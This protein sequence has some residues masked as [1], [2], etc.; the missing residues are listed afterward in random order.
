MAHGKKKE[1]SWNW[2]EKGQR[3]KCIMVEPNITFNELL[4]EIYGSTEIDH[5]C[6]D[7]EL[8]YKP[9]T[10]I[11]IAPIAVKNDKDVMAFICWQKK[12]N[13]PLCVTL[14]EF[15]VKGEVLD[16]LVNLEELSCSCREFDIDKIPCAQAI[17]AAKHRGSSIEK[18]DAMSNHSAEF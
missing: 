1:G 10:T 15:N 11:D 13:I 12:D 6:F 17:A 7:V 16:G 4:D 3:S 9:K 18:L 8:S 14:F 2:N 5:N